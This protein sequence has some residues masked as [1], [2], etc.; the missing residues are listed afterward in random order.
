MTNSTCYT[1][2]LNALEESDFSS[3]E[4]KRVFHGRGHCFPALE[5]INLDFYPP[6]LFL[7]SYQ[8]ILQLELDQLA[9]AI[10]AKI[11]N[12]VDNIDGLVFQQRAGRA[13]TS[14]VLYGNLP[15]PHIIREHGLRYQVD[16]LKHQN[17]G[18]FPDMS[19]GREFILTHSKD[20]KVLNLFSYTCGF[21]LAAMK[22]GAKSVVNMDMN[23]GVLKQ[24]RVNH[25][26][27]NFTQ[28]V[29]FYPHDILKSF[30]K[31]R[32]TGPFDLI[33][34]DPPSF[35]KG[36]FELTKD[37]QKILRRLPDITCNGAQL[38]L[39]ANSPDLS[40]EG[41]KT[42]ISEHAGEAFIFEYR[43]NNATGFPEKD[44]DRN[45]KALVYRYQKQEGSLFLI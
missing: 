32:K 36:S 7:T 16:L 9:S 11:A 8:E 27:N 29:N 35:Q 26:L 1:P 17:T 24:G 14:Q 33:I 5:H 28:N 37:Y 25:K 40:E 20:K 44:L 39:C 19:R 31:L 34:I 43:I 4:L 38:L 12:I 22:G 23:N 3:N 42:L 10:W 6:F 30:G 21:S 13:T 18:I 41:F 15:N 2:I 45:L